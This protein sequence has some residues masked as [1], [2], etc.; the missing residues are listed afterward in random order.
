VQISLGS[1][2]EYEFVY[3]YRQLKSILERLNIVK[4]K[5]HHFPIKTYACIKCS[6]SLTTLAIAVIAKS[7]ARLLKFV[8]LQFVDRQRLMSSTEPHEALLRWFHQRYAGE[9]RS[10]VCL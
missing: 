2:Y 4:V 7:S 9:L 8:F 5:G 1:R 10:I 6:G 3:N